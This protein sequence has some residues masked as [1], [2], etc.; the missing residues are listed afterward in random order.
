MIREHRGGEFKRVTWDEALDY[1]AKKLLETKEKYG[2]DSIYVTGSSRGTGNE[3]NL[4]MQK[5]ARACIGTNNID[6]CA[7]T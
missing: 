7:R 6:N 2:P 3:S 1:V 5:F 4:I